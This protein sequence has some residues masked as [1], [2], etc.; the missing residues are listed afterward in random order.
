MGSE[1]GKD[2]LAG[3]GLTGCMLSAHTG[4][5]W[6]RGQL[7]DTVFA[8][9]SQED[10]EERGFGLVLLTV[11]QELSYQILATLALAPM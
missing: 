5:L 8:D 4:L 11:S 1:R 3:V 6:W 7:A 2:N 9:I 10:S